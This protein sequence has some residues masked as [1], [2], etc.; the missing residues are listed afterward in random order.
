MVS[1]NGLLNVLAVSAPHSG[2][3]ADDKET[4]WNEVFHLMSCM[5]QNEMIVLSGDMNWHVG[6]SNV[7]YETGMQMDLGS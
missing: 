7:G 4:F 2:K 6:T 5:S 1:D 3:L